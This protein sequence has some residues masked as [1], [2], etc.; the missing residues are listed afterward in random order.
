MKKIL[1]IMALFLISLNAK[2]RL[3]VLDPASIETLFMLNAG[4]QIVGIASLQHSQIYPEDKTSKLTSVGTFSNPSL[5]KIVALR[6][7][8]VI[9]S[10]Y[11]LNLEE[12]LKNFGIKSIYL[13]AERLEDITK[14]I[15][16]LGQI[17]QKEKKAELL[18]QELRQNLKKLSDKPLN[19]S[20]IYL[21]SSNPLMAFN[22]N[23]LMA[24]IL[25][26]IGLKNLSPQ[27]PVSRPVISAEYILKQNPDFLILGINAGENLLSTN[28]LLKNTKAAKTGQIYINKD[29]H[30]LLRLSPKIVD[31]IEEFKSKLE[32]NNF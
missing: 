30:T 2:E 18:K 16:S 17:T 25:R 13:K 10:S 3:V 32:K 19:K 8:L 6:P 31:R 26:L 14:N 27:S 20:A 9:L 12:G 15:T 1:M 29:T 28:T 7:T 4:E 24:D 11:S 5:E 23:S 21:Y 22:D